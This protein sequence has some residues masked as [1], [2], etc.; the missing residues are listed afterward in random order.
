MSAAILEI[1]HQP[2]LALFVIWCVIGA[3]LFRR[4]H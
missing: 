4:K 2:Q 3:F 1:T